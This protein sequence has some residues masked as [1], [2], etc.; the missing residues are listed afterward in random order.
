MNNFANIVRIPLPTKNSC[1]LNSLLLSVV[2]LM[3]ANFNSK[4]N[5][6]LSDIKWVLNFPKQEI[7]EFL[8]YIDEPSIK[9]VSF[10]FSLK[11]C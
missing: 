1:N 8:V 9:R 10:C 11:K 4:Y 6:N 3:K 5:N 2:T 7:T